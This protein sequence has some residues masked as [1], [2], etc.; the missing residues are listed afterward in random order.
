MG[1]F[2]IPVF[3][4]MVTLVRRI[5]VTMNEMVRVVDEF[6]VTGVLVL[7]LS[8]SLPRKHLMAPLIVTRA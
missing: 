2:W 6:D 4:G 1:G 5:K 8:K 3:T 7:D